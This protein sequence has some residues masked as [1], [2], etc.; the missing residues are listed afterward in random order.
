MR[1]NSLGAK[2]RGSDLALAQ[3]TAKWPNSLEIFES[4]QQECKEAGFDYDLGVFIRNLVVFATGQS[5][6]NT[7][8]SLSLEKLKSEW[9]YSKQ[10]FTCAINFL[11]SNIG[12]DSH[13]LL[14]TPFLIIALGFYA[15]KN[16]FSF[17]PDIQQKLRYWLLVANAKGRYSRGSSETVLDQDLATI[18]RTEDLSAMIQNLERQFGRL[19]V[20][21]EDLSG[22][23]SQS[24]YFK[25]MFLIFKKH[26]ALDWFN[27]VDISLKLSGAA[28]KLQ[29]HHI[30][31]RD[32]M[33]ARFKPKEINDIANQCFISS[34]TNQKL[35]NKAPSK[36]LPEVIQRIGKEGLAK[37]CIPTREDLWELDNYENFLTERRRLLADAINEFIG[38]KP[39]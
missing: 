14:S 4:F 32:L 38:S 22:R 19:D 36:Y 23:N 24:A 18:S 20:L 2:L 35:G 16:G 8:S 39:L 28:Y 27:G 25:T 11:K 34:K 33:K 17:P 7:V 15:K 13:A 9:E 31:P 5:K 37:H 3:I 10:G 6:F 30:F 1:V 29:F 21:P 26:E 12:I